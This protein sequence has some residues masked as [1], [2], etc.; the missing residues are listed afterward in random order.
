MTSDHLAAL[1]PKIAALTALTSLDLW[2]NGLTELPSEIAALTVLTSLNLGGNGLTELPSEIAALTAL[3]SLDLWGNGLTE[4]PSEIAALTALTSLDLERNG[5]TELPSEITALTALMSLHLRGNHLTELPS[6]IGALAALTSLDLRGNGLAELPAEIGALAALTSLD[7]R[8]NGLAELPA[9]IGALTALT[10]LNLGDNGLAEL[11]SEI[12]ELTA[13]TNLNLGDNGLTE[14]PPEIAALTVLTSLNLGGNGLTELPSEIDALTALTNLNLGGNGLTE[15]P[16]EIGALTALT[17]LDLGFNGLTVLP[18]EIGAL[19]ALTELNLAGNGLTELPPEIAALT[20]LTSLNLG[21]NGL[22]ELPSEIGALTALTSLDLRVNGLAELPAEIGALTALTELSLGDNGLA[23]L[24]A[25]IGALTA[26]TRLDLSDNEG[27]KGLPGEIGNLA[28]AIRIRVSGT[29]LVNP[30]GRVV[31][32]GPAA[33]RRYFE[34]RDEAGTWVPASDIVSLLLERRS[35]WALFEAVLLPCVVLVLAASAW[36]H[37]LWTACCIAPLVL[38]RTTESVDDGISA[39]RAVMRRLGVSSGPGFSPRFLVVTKLA[40]L[41]LAATVIRFLV[42]LWHMVTHPWDAVRA[43]PSNYRRQLLVIDHRTPVELVPGLERASAQWPDET[44]TVSA[45]RRDFR[46]DEFFQWI[47][48]DMHDRMLSLLAILGSGVFWLAAWAYRFSV[49]ASAVVW[50]PFLCFGTL[51]TPDSLIARLRK[52]DPW[53]F[54]SGTLPFGGFLA[55][56]ASAV[57]ALQALAPGVEPADILVELFPETVADLLPGLVKLF[58]DYPPPNFELRWVFVALLGIAAF[59]V[60]GKL[61][62]ALLS[63]K[64][65]E[66]EDAPPPDQVTVHLFLVK[67]WQILGNAA[68]AAWTVLALSWALPY[69]SDIWQGVRGLLS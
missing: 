29:P 62:R 10:E 1:L 22:T 25:E 27:L 57:Y 28:E 15:L 63:H 3:T 23:E 54:L 34:L 16:S 38:F 44:F 48:D 41:G 21:G 11:P 40:L 32:D 7:L 69:T 37:V 9:E 6:E 24:P 39:F 14:L 47:G 60:L 17:R 67:L 13:L 50:W 49:K 5:L 46:R 18:A 45:L 2:G 51:E 30:P 68:V 55:L 31:S 4:L 12:G 8:G 36:P 64:V 35:R 19:T 59:G 56:G 42:T 58:A 26:L 52:S 33:I 65:R 43:V 20:V 53:D 61:Q 66:A